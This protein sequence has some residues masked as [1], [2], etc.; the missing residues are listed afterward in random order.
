MKIVQ[1]FGE[2]VFPEPA[3]VAAATEKAHS[4]TSTVDKV[5][6]TVNEPGAP[7][8]ATPKVEAEETERKVTTAER[9]PMKVPD[10]VHVK[11]SSL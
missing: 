3:A 7:E 6:P 8:T 1:D 11:F 9:K 5:D 2:E 10:S 4:D